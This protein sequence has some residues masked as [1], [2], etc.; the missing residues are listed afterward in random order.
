MLTRI[1]FPV[2]VVLGVAVALEVRAEL[3]TRWAVGEGH[4]VVGNVVEEVN[5]VLGKH[6]GRSN[7]VHRGITPALVEETAIP[8]E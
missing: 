6:E 5:L 1:P 8:V 4:V 3:L 2:K 7:R